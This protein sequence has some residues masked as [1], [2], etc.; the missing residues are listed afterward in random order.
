V[1]V[2]LG[3]SG[4]IAAY[5]ACEIVRGLDRASVEVQVILTRNA[6]EF[7]TPLTLQTLSRRRVLLEPFTLEQEQTIQ[8]IELTRRIAALVVAPATANILAKFAHGVADD[9]L[10]TFYVSVTAPVIVAPAMNTRMWL[11]PTTREN[12]GLLRRRGVHVVEPASGWLAE[13]ETGWGRLASPESI[14]EA[15]LGAARRSSQL[16]GKR[17]LVTA[18][19]TREPI[20]PVRYLSNRS[21]GKMGYAVA[22]AAARRGADVVLISGPVDLAPPFGV[23]HVPVATV[24][25]MRQAVLRHRPGAEAVFMAA[26]VSDYVPRAASS[27]IKKDG[28]SLTLTLEEGPDILEELG[29]KR[30]ERILVGF[31]AETESLLSNAKAKLA[32]KNL[33]FIV[34]N[35]VSRSDVGFEVDDNAVTILDRDG[36]RH[37]VPR[38]AKNRIAEA[39]LD[40]VF[41]GVRA[42]AVPDAG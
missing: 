11:H 37:E 34:A 42:D 32:R 15:T 41:G 24:S 7:V 16:A 18:G 27:K 26:A 22:A 9:L 29:R 19:P 6:T 12:V 21:S 35:D 3:V 17:I 38:A 39:I 36:D 4:G 33:D 23:R 40:R 25:E 13:G 8:H 20:D 14:V 2:A 31:A 28:R 1:L 10:S 30:E 5:K